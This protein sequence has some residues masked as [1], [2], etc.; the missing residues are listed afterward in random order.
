MDNIEAMQICNPTD[1][2]FEIPTSLFLL[3]FGVLNN[4]VEKLSVFNILHHQEKMSTG[5]D[6]FVQLYYRRMPD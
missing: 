3:Y 4:I 1:Y 6:N 5:L 2:L